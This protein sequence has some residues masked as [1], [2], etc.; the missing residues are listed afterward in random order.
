MLQFLVMKIQTSPQKNLAHRGVGENMR[1]R[2][3]ASALPWHLKFD[4]A[5]DTAGYEVREIEPVDIPPTKARRTIAEGEPETWFLFAKGGPVEEY[6]L[7]D[8]ESRD[9]GKPGFAEFANIGLPGGGLDPERLIEFANRYGM[10]SAHAQSDGR[11]G[12]RNI[13]AWVHYVRRALS[14]IAAEKK[15][16]I[17]LGR[18]AIPEAY[19]TIVDTAKGVQHQLAFEVQSLPAFL[20]MQMLL[21]VQQGI[22]IKRC[23]I[24]GNFMAPK[25]ASRDT[26]SEAC[27]QR[28]Y[29]A[30]DGNQATHGPHDDNAH[31]K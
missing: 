19:L 17:R 21:A 25:S 14:A 23:V 29:R 1:I 10:P 20:S 30:R 31:D 2:K 11:E 12:L 26:C 6:H 22:S 5:V 15:G 7:N 28:Q 27:R 16:E 18:L 13:A 9:K 4:W 3:T 8:F 24:C